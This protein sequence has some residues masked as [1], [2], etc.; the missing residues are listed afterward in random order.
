MWSRFATTAGVAAVTIAGLLM[1]PALSA[2]QTAAYRAPRTADGKPNLNG[3]WQAMN[4]AN[5]DIQAHS[6]GPSLV[7]ELGAIAAVPGGVGIVEGGSIPYR[8]EALAKKKENQAN[9]LKLDPEIRCYLPGVPRVMYMPFP[10]QII[11]SQQHIMMVFEYAG[12]IRTIY[13][14]HHI[15]APADSW[16]GWSNGHWEG[17]TL[18]IDTT[19]FN[20]L[21]WLDRAGD[22]HSDELHVVER[23][24]AR[25]PETLSY[26]ATIE[27]PK[28]FT[29]PWK[30]SMPL[31]RHVEPNAQLSEFRCVEFVEDLMYGH[32]RKQPSR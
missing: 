1:T 30:I 2:G 17:E 25:S 9:R 8:P 5:W 19:G 18:V 10:F 32:L 13:M 16:M 6:A 14:D 29:K 24:T 22:F 27:D 26:E 12:A 3:I 21:S 15:E 31:Y 7:Q 4:S 23:I 20:D 11:Q 28:V